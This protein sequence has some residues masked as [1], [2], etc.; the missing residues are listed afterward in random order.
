MCRLYLLRLFVLACESE[1]LHRLA[2]LFAVHW[3]LRIIKIPGARLSERILFPDDIIGSS[4][5]KEII[6]KLIW[7]ELVK[8]LV[9][10]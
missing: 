8:E 9:Q 3:S 1:L 5:E 4:F 10:M 7:F 6:Y 2:S